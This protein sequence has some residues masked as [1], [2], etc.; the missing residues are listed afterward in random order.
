MKNV[1]LVS[2]M[3]LVLFV[4]SC[5]GGETVQDDVVEDSDYV[6]VDPPEEVGPEGEED[7][8]PGANTAIAGHAFEILDVG[9]QQQHQYDGYQGNRVHD[10]PALI[11]GTLGDS[12]VRP[13]SSIE[14]NFFRRFTEIEGRYYQSPAPTFDDVT[15]SYYEDGRFKEL[16][17]AALTGNGLTGKCRD[18]VSIVRGVLPPSTY[19]FVFGEMSFPMS[20][21]EGDSL[22]CLRKRKILHSELSLDHPLTLEY[23]RRYARDGNCKA[24]FGLIKARSNNFCVW[25]PGEQDTRN[26]DASVNNFVTL[27][28]F[29]TLGEL[30]Y[31]DIELRHLPGRNKTVG[32][33]IFTADNL[34][35]RW[36]HHKYARLN[37]DQISKDVRIST[38]GLDANAVIVARAKWSGSSVPYVHDVTFH[39]ES[40]FSQED[41]RADLAEV[42]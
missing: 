13:L 12:D 38:E 8:E 26:R 22:R 27:R 32:M 33:H 30:K 18:N 23:K 9:A 5:G 7:Y 41:I 19:P 29:A 28:P 3:V 15:I 20:N 42:N 34:F 16:T 35:G 4:T 37:K 10:S 31:V 1:M 25:S 24:A 36:V 6:H 11:A 17:G 21:R 39:Y 14:A 40:E 2:L